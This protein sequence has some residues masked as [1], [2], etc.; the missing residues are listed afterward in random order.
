V[1]EVAGLM[2]NLRGINVEMNT[3]ILDKGFK[4]QI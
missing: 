3:A 2:L 1:A 4:G